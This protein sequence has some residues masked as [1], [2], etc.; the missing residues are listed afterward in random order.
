LPQEPQTIYELGLQRKAARA[1][2]NTLLRIEFSGSL[3]IGEEST[4][5]GSISDESVLIKDKSEDKL[6]DP[7]LS[8]I[9]ESVESLLQEH[10]VESEF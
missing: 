10:R 2:S 8:I 1:P 3:E 6:M 7:E 5:I 4:N 9:E